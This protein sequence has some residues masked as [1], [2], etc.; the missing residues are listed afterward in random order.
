MEDNTKL[1]RDEIVDLKIKFEKLAMLFESEESAF[2]LFK[3]SPVRYLRNS[4]LEIMK[5]INNRVDRYF[6]SRFSHSIKFALRN[7]IV[8][9]RCLWCKI[10][11]LT[12][13]YATCGKAGLALDGC[14]TAISGILE[15]V[16]GV[17]NVSNDM[18]QS[19]VHMLTSLNDRLSPYKMAR[20]ICV[21]LGFCL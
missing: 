8:F 6:T 5:Y 7:K 10:L 14:R 20:L 2:L 12:V 4:D 13:F 21:H 3:S 9:D 18:I 17:L 15:A 11:A 16:Q 1:S 19:I